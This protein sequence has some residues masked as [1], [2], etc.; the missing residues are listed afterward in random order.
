MFNVNIEEIAIHIR[1]QIDP[2]ES[3]FSSDDL[4]R[5]IGFGI[6]FRLGLGLMRG[7]FEKISFPRIEPT[8]ENLLAPSEFYIDIAKNWC[9]SNDIGYFSR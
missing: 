1:A 8:Q 7:S 5:F 3:P 2:F 9:K 6:N 4:L